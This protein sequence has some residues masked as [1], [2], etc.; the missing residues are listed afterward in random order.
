MSLG[1]RMW[2]PYNVLRNLD[3][4]FFDSELSWSPKVN[5]AKKD[6]RY[7]VTVEL[8]GVSKED[9]D[10]DIK[11]DTLTIRGEK[12]VENKGEKKN[13]I[14]VERSYGKFERSFYLSDDVDKNSIKAAYKDGV[15]KIE[16]KKKEEAK[17]KQINIET[18]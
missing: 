16:L 14:R 2:E 4:S 13:Y 8:P 6:D 1:L 18:N 5:V 7:V 15:L 9:I 17:P 11:D 10:I 3:N 12:K